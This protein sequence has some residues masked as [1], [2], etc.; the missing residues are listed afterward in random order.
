M[1]EEIV[2]AT[3]LLS[4]N[5]SLEAERAGEHGRGFMVVAG[6]VGKLSKSTNSSLEEIET[7][8]KFLNQQSSTLS[9]KITEQGAFITNGIHFIQSIEEISANL[10]TRAKKAS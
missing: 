3:K 9:Q 6:E 1:I 5:A 2:L 8:A 4:F 7:V 10:N